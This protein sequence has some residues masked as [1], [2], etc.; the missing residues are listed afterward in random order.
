MHLSMGFSERFMDSKQ[1]VMKD[2]QSK[3]H[4]GH[5]FY[6]QG[7]KSLKVLLDEPAPKTEQERLPTDKC[8]FIR[9]FTRFLNL[10]P[11]LSNRATCI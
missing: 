3:C 2:V 4:L 5:A 10:C 6:K 11:R 9:Q 7:H 8:L 1:S